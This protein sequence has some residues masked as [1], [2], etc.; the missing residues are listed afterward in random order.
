VT[1]VSVVIPVYRAELTLGELHRQLVPVIESLTN[2]FEIIFVEDCGGDSSWSIIESL[3][4][5]D[6]RVRGIRLNRNFGQHNALLCE[7]APRGTTSCSR[8]TTTFNTRSPRLSR[9]WPR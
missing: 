5:A 7:S 6:P 4:A 8:W 1:T 9:C 3:A 2:A